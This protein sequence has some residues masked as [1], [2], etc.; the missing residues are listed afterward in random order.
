VFAEPAFRPVLLVEY[1]RDG[2]TCR[3]IIG[4][5]IHEDR[6]DAEAEL[7]SLLAAFPAGVERTIWYD[8]RDREE[9][10]FVPPLG[11]LAV[12]VSVMRILLEPFRSA[13]QVIREWLTRPR[14]AEPASSPSSRGRVLFV[15][16][17]LVALALFTRY[18]VWRVYRVL[19]VYRPTEGKVLVS[20]VMPRGKSGFE[21]NIRICYWIDGHYY[22]R[23]AWLGSSPFRSQSHDEAR[24]AAA[25]YPAGSEVVVWYDPDMPHRARIE[26]Y[27]LWWLYPLVIP[28]IWFLALQA[29]RLLRRK[30]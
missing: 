1:E 11:T 20:D 18:I 2:A 22:E 3:G 10:A 19:F 30:R 12:L 7:A 21:P 8:R 24:I 14:A 15:V 4:G 6:N 26:R 29:R 16:V 28:P 9:P 5:G 27:I 17:A 25:R 23:P 13:V